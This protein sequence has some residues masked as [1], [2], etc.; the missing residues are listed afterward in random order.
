MMRGSSHSIGRERGNQGKYSIAPGRAQAGE[1]ASIQA[2]GGRGRTGDELLCDGIF[3]G[4]LRRF[5][6][7]FDAA[8]GE[9]RI[10]DVLL[11]HALGVEE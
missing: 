5:D 9:I 1:S 2:F 8:L 10:E 6:G 3:E 7:F 4:R 11:E